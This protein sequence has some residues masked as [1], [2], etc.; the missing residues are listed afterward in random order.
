MNQGAFPYAGTSGWSG[1][2]TSFERAINDDLSGT[3]SDR[4]I[5]AIN[6]LGWAGSIGLTWKELA[7]SLKLHH[8]QASGVLSVLH[9]TGIIERL[10][11]RRN[12]CAIYVLPEYV[13]GRQTAS[14]ANTKASSDNNKI[15]SAL[16]YIEFSFNKNQMSLLDYETLKAILND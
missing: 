1:S 7:Q 10:T 13:D 4:Q 2:E 16:K 14:H 6:E 3:T 11:D 5:Q 8:G 9:K 15:I 12:K